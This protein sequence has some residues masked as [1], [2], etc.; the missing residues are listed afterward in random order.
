[1]SVEIGQK[2]IRKRKSVTDVSLRVVSVN[3]QYVEL[4]RCEHHE[5]LTHESFPLGIDYLL[6]HYEL[7]EVADD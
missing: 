7:S 2:Y 4:E 3:S 5:G 6:E 1:M